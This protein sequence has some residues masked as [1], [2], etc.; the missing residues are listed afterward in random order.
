MN[1]K[2][3][4]QALLFENSN[5]T[6][7]KIKELYKI[8]NQYQ[9]EN[10]LYFLQ[11]KRGEASFVHNEI[12]FFLFLS[13]T[14]GINIGSFSDLKRLLNP[15]SRAQNIEYSGNSKNSYIAVFDSVVLLKKYGELAKLYKLSDLSE[16]EKID[17]ILAIEN[18]ETFL[19]IE[20]YSQNFK[21]EYYVYLSGYA[22]SLTRDFLSSKSVNFFVD[23][24]IEGMNIYES[25][26]CRSKS[27]HI[28][29]NIENYF[30]DKK[31][32]NPEL[33]KKQRDRFKEE[34]SSNVMP[35]I[36]LIKKYNTVVE[37]EIIYEAY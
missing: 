23:F 22:N 16:L 5:P 26:Q 19:N 10:C 37:Q 12:D 15:T 27:L 18:G 9:S 20:K 21:A 30:L 33:Y 34:Y 1:R 6:F 13:Q 32:H 29:Q 3:L 25:F 4:N 28:P 8:A 31:C 11:A 35:I 7:S 17:N 2:I 36:E 14:Q 24:D